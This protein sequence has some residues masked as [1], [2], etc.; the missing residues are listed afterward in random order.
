MQP[1]YFTC[2]NYKNFMVL[3]LQLFR[4]PPI[5]LGTR[6]NISSLDKTVAMVAMAESVFEGLTDDGHN[7]ISLPHQFQN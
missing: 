4:N 3:L 5:A 2:L 6:K 1:G 7:K